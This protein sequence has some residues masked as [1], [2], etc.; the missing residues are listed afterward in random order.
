M[1]TK[2]HDYHLVNPSPWPLVGAVAAFALALGA[3]AYM[4]G[5]SLLWTVPGL[6]GVDPDV[7]PGQHVSQPVRGQRVG[8]R[9]GSGCHGPAQQA[10]DFPTVVLA[11]AWADASS[12]AAWRRA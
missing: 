8:A 10:H 9:R 12:S 4:H 11:D 3:I 5:A 6:L 7:V 1:A 2:H